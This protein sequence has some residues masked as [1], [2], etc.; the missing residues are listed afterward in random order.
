MSDTVGAADSAKIA[1]I[2]GVASEG[3]ANVDGMTS[4]AG[5]GHDSFGGPHEPAIAGVK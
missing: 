3:M 5:V 1:R 2:V 4:F